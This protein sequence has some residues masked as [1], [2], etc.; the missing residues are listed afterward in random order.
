MENIFN[1]TNVSI[2]KTTDFEKLLLNTSLDPNI[3]NAYTF[4]LNAYVDILGEAYK[5]LAELWTWRTLLSRNGLE[6]N[7]IEVGEVS[8][9]GVEKNDMFLYFNNIYYAFIE[10]PIKNGET[11]IF[12]KELKFYE[13][14]GKDLDRF[15]LIGKQ[16]EIFN[17]EQI[18]CAISFEDIYI[19]NCIPD[20][21]IRYNYRENIITEINDGNTSMKYRITPMKEHFGKYKKQSYINNEVIEKKILVLNEYTRNYCKTYRK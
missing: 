11:Q 13:K 15:R 4:M 7:V 6:E 20:Y 19:S 14:C 16:I 17:E 21:N 8:K 12:K 18:Y 10:T 1:D 3:R 9:Y 5:E 2:K